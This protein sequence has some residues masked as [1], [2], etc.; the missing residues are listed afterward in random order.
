MQKTRSQDGTTLAYERVGEGQPLILVLGACNDRKTG[1]PLAAAL[2]RHFSVFSYDR[3]GRGDSTDA[4]TY[5][6]EREVEDF[7]AMLAVAGGAANVFGYSS[8]AM[9]ALEAAGSGLPLRKLALYELPPGTA[10]EHPAQLR[11]LVEAGRR[12]DA[13]EYFQER[14]VGIPAQVVQQLRAAPFRKGLEAIAHTLV[15]DT[16]LTTRGRASP[17]LLAKVEPPTLAIAGGAS[18][19]SMRE[20]S[21]ALARQLPRGKSCV[22]E[23]A[24]HDLDPS[25]LAP[26][27][28]DFFG[29]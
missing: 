15:Y 12:G 7:E 8:G 23:G 3:R 14:V 16:T 4:A 22:L 28:L 5:A 26:V 6:V 19:P 10:P 1:A 29:A 25:R 21:E 24:T 27:L 13:L 2:S 9:L 11:A 18:I 17:E 20:V